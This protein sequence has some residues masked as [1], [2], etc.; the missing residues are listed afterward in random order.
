MSEPKTLAS[1]TA[2][3]PTLLHRL[4]E[5]G[6][7]RV[8]ASY[9]VIAWLLLQV[10]S[11]VFDPLGVPKWVMTALILAAATGFP[12]ALAVAWSF[13][14]GEHGI[15]F[16]TA[17]E[18]RA[19]PHV[20]GWRRYADAIVIGLLVVTVAVLLV[21][22][23]GLGRPKPP[24]NPAI[25]VLPFD[26]LSRDP[27][28]EYFSDGLAEEMLDRLGRVPG[29]KVI[30]SSS[31]F[32]FKHRDVE[33]TEVA[34]RLGVT[35]VLV[36]SVRRSGK[37]LKL[38]ARLIDGASGRQVWSGSFDR[39]VNDIFAVQA[40]LAGAIVNALVPA[41][42]GEV[43]DS[44]AAPT[45]N[46]NAYD[47]YLL[48]RTQLGLR[49]VDSMRK[50]VE[51]MERAVELDPKF[52]RAHAH[53]A[54]SLLFAR[55]YEVDPKRDQEFLER[56]QASIY[57]ALA[58]DPK[59]SEA[60]DAQGNLL[61]DTAQPG[62]ED[63][64]K[65]AL[66]LNPNNAAA[67]HDYAVFLGNNSDRRAESKRA[68][69]RSLELDPR[70]PVTWANYL[71]GVRA[72]GRQRFEAE[73]ARAIRTVGD[74]PEATARF[75]HPIWS[76]DRSGYRREMSAR[77]GEAHGDALALDGLTMPEAAIVGFPDVVMQAALLKPQP[78][79]DAE[80]PIALNLYRAWSP[81]DL[82]R[83]EKAITTDRPPVRH[84]VNYERA[85]LYLQSEVAGL[86]QDWPR[87]DRVLAKLQS[88]VGDDDHRVDSVRAFWLSVQ[89]RYKE[90]A[91]ELEKAEPL[92]E[93]RVPPVLGGD[94]RWGLME[95][96]KVRILRGS[97]RAEDARRFAQQSLEQMRREWHTAHAQCDWDGWMMAPMRYPSLAANEGL[98]EEAVAALRNALRCGDLPYGF[99]PQLPWFRSLE[100]YAPYDALLRERATRVAQARDELERMQAAGGKTVTPAAAAA[101]Q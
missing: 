61:R 98:K 48:A 6:V 39:E 85:Y 88:R 83:A 80:L 52:A 37:R 38:N 20:V 89:G 19:R 16:D 60:Y 41:A 77:I 34:R 51:L 96:A 10:G 86:Q 47:L 8:A 45:T 55:S 9:A 70:Q 95:T 25:A 91:V 79:G 32:G 72:E 7:L 15:E 2:T 30:A 50:S 36:G 59:L 53:L 5:R 35:S 3:R 101:A 44:P 18:G 68:T 66:A 29:L 62:A 31:S 63:A 33:V 73:L 22:Q 78:Q 69:A 13:E 92:P 46:L 71:T 21:R 90:G 11:I 24:A 40:E 74:M 57:R 42:R 43:M 99:W 56:A 100:G 17:A 12:V 28:Q 93:E 67:W 1:K 97:G 84:G 65:R 75:P 14:L 82:D 87:V 94:M 81:V 26:N 64:Y 49:T 58:L 4:R 23:Y 54:A 27:E 76:N